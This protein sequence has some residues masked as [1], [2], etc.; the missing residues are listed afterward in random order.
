MKH[1]DI[2]AEEYEEQVPEHIRL[3]FLDKKTEMIDRKLVE[4]GIDKKKSKGVDLGCGL[5]WYVQEMNNKGYKIIGLD[6]SIKAIKIARKKYPASYFIVGNAGRLPFENE[7]LDFV[8]SI[9]TFHHL[10]INTQKQAFKE[11]ERVLKPG[12]YFVIHEINTR[13]PLFKLYMSYIF[14][15]I[16][17]IDTGDEKWIPARNLN[18]YSNLNIIE[19]SYFTFTPDFTPK[20]LFPIIR[21]IESFLERTPIRKYGIH[22]MAILKK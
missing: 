4:F 13:N 20:L 18:Q 9:N 21:K 17:K 6:N 19:V 3:H 2:I 15:K 8:Y 14:P 22:Y 7:S 5:G 16:N 10:L 12:G 11:I 1:F